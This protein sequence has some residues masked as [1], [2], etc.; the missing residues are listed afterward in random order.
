MPHQLPVELRCIASV[1]SA[2][3][4]M[5]SYHLNTRLLTGVPDDLDV[6]SSSYYPD[7]HSARD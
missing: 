5:I 6:V 4:Q 2:A 3:S 1:G 7:S